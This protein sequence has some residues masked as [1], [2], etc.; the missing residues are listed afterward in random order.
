MHHRCVTVN[1][2]HCEHISVFLS[3]CV[4]LS[5]VRAGI[6]RLQSQDFSKPSR[7]VSSE[8]VLIHYLQGRWD[9]LS[10]HMGTKLTIHWQ[11]VQD[12]KV[13]LVS[14]QSGSSF[15]WT[16]RAETSGA[17]TQPH[18]QQAIMK[19]LLM[20]LQYMN[21]RMWNRNISLSFTVSSVNCYVYL[22]VFFMH[23]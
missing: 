12:D 13:Q 14:Q 16:G 18:H 2:K 6:H 11:Q 5:C 15:Y 4:C 8:K 20:W 9:T 10:L 22:V 3:V 1:L 19:A 17:T 23:E 21:F 7:I